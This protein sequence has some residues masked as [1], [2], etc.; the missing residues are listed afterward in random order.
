[1][2]LL[3]PP[4]CLQYTC[5]TNGAD[6]LNPSNPNL[7]WCSFTNIV[8]Q[9]TGTTGQYDGTTVAVGMYCTSNTDGYVF[10]ITRILSSPARTAASVDVIVEDIGG[11]NALVDPTAGIQ[12]GAPATSSIGYVFQVNPLT[13]LPVLTSVNNPPTLTFP[14]SIMGRF[15]Y[16]QTGGGGGTTFA[17]PTGSV[18]FTTN[19]TSLTG[20]TAFIYGPTGLSVR[21]SLSTTYLSLTETG[22][23]GSTGT[24]WRNTVTTQPLMYGSN[25]VC[26][27]GGIFDCGLSV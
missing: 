5:I 11:F 18:A 19:G 13:K 20:S 23:T 22:T 14:D 7:Y 6:P 25:A 3:S 17:G 27:Q 4:I 16:E 26:V 15:T 8:P 10:R 9:I 12:G 24:I 2:A 1:M 21:G